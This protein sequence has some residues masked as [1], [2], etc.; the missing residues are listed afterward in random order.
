MTPKQTTS[1][2]SL[3]EKIQLSFLMFIINILKN[4]KLLLRA[5]KVILF[6]KIFF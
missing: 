6:L 3:T 4:V 5:M 1:R 2:E